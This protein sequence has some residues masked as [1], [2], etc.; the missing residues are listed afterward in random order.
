M[1]CTGVILAGGRADRYGGAPKGLERV[2]GLRVIDRVATALAAASDD[3][4]LVANDPQS[5]T[6]LSGVRTRPD[7]RAGL[8]VLG[9][10]HAALS[11]AGTPVLVVAWDMPFVASS[12]LSALRAIGEAG[13]DAALPESG[14]PRGVEP[15]CAWYAPA[16]LPAIERTLDAGDHRAIAFLAAVRTARLPAAQVAEHGDPARLFLNINTPSDLALAERYATSPNARDRR[17]EEAR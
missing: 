12:L 10:L 1:R 8:G 16:C 6:W 11:H 13:H 7:L 9:G 5:A 4:L 14:G 17:Q 2:G 3:M 15:L